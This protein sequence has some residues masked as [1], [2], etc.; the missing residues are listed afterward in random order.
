MRVLERD[1]SAAGHE[2]SPVFVL[3][4]QVRCEAGLDWTGDVEAQRR[5]N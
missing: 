5:T 2:Q 3:N 4:T 1:Y